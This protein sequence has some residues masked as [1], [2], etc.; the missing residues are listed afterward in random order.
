[1]TLEFGQRIPSLSPALPWAFTLPA[2]LVEGRPRQDPR[3]D[4]SHHTIPSTEEK[5]QLKSMQGYFF[6]VTQDCVDIS[7]IS[8]VKNTRI[9]TGV[10]RKQCLF[11]GIP[12]YP[13]SQ[14]ITCLMEGKP[15]KTGWAPM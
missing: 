10:A 2:S 11:P 13:N 7:S 12:S 9:I 4:V 5:A 14:G 8:K 15:Q 3:A 1:M 6:Q